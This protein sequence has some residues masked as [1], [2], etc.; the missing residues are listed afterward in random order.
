MIPAAL[1]WVSYSFFSTPHSKSLCG[2]SHGK[3]KRE[4]SSG[5]WVQLVTIPL[6][7]SWGQQRPWHGRERAGVHECSFEAMKGTVGIK[8][9]NKLHMKANL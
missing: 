9:T 1:N 5:E 8:F 4:F 2:I 7:S 6:N 3:E